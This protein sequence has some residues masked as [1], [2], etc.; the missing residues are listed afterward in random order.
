MEKNEKGKRNVRDD[1]KG[2][3]QSFVENNKLV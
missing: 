2:C 1:G 3:L